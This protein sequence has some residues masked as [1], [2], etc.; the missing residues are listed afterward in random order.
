MWIYVDMLVGS[1]NFSNMMEDLKCQFLKHLLCKSDYNILLPP[2]FLLS[3]TGT[4]SS[5]PPAAGVAP[6]PIPTLCS[7]TK[8]G[9]TGT[10]CLGGREP[11]GD[12]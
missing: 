6:S 3:C 9:N 1:H 11:L 12:F 10:C 5:G 8:L 2:L 7:G 4:I